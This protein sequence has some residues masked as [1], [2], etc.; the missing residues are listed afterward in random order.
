MLASRYCG[1]C[2][3]ELSRLS[4]MLE[5][6]SSATAAACATAQ[7]QEMATLMSRR[8]LASWNPL[9]RAMAVC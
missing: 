5:R 7:S 4:I 6:C 8:P 9:R 1:C 3:I 2:S